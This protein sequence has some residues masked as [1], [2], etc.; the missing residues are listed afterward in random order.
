MHGMVFRLCG[1]LTQIESGYFE[2]IES[3]A[4]ILRRSMQNVRYQPCSFYMFF[5]IQVLR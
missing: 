2:I 1:Y 5:L 4:S 3:V